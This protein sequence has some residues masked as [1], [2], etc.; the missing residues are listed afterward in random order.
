VADLVGT[1]WARSASLWLL[2]DVDLD[3]VLLVEAAA[4]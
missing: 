4:E 2:R 3:P 1:T